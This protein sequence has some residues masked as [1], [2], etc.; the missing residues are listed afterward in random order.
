MIPIWL[1]RK[2]QEILSLDETI[3]YDEAEQEFD[4]SEL[5][6]L[7]ND[8]V[9]TDNRTPT[10]INDNLSGKN[11]VTQTPQAD[12]ATA[13]DNSSNG[14]DGG[15]PILPTSSHTRTGRRLKPNPKYQDYLT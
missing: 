15:L 9:L 2:R 4:D 6:N 13:N 3:P 8:Q 11:T 7:F 14:D 5:N 10:T 12:T 1:R